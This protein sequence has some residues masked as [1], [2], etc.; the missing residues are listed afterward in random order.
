MVGLGLTAAAGRGVIVW[1]G[2]CVLVIEAV[3]TRN[4]FFGLMSFRGVF[5]C[6]VSGRRRGKKIEIKTG[7][8]LHCFFSF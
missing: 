8:F 6:A 3:D 1:R 7:K 2:C 4:I 5:G